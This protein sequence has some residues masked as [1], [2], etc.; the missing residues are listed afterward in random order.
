MPDLMRMSGRAGKPLPGT[1]TDAILQLNAYDP[2]STLS[3]Y[4]AKRGKRKKVRYFDLAHF[5]KDVDR[6]IEHLEA[7]Y[8]D[9][10]Q[11][12]QRKVISESAE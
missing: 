2:D 12:L 8:V 6:V 10:Q 1:I 3:R 9:L 7:L 4:P 5:V 11:D